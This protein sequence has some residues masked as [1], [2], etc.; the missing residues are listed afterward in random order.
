MCCASIRTQIN[1]VRVLELI[2]CCI[3]AVSWS[4]VCFCS[5]FVCAC[6]LCIKKLDTRARMRPLLFFITFIYFSHSLLL[7]GRI[8]MLNSF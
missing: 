5:L 6:S 2:C 8:Y 4:L 3:F 7:A 1:V